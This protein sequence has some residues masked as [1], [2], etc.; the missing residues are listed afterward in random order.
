M[1]CNHWGIVCFLGLIV[2][3]VCGSM[4]TLTLHT[5]D[6]SDR[7]DISGQ[8]GSWCVMMI[9][10]STVGNVAGWAPCGLHDLA[11]VFVCWIRK[12]QILRNAPHNGRRRRI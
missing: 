11:R 5:A 6:G 1:A 2:S 4:A 3:S 10:W 8:I 12:I 7:L 9:A